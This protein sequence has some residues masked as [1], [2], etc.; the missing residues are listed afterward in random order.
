M[1]ISPCLIVLS[2]I[3]ISL[4]TPR[5]SLALQTALV[6]RYDVM[7]SR[8]INDPFDGLIVY[9]IDSG[10]GTRG[11]LGIDTVI[12]S[13]SKKEIRVSCSGYGRFTTTQ[14]VLK[15]GIANGRQYSYYVDEK[16]TNS[17]I[18]PNVLMFS[19]RGKIYTY[20]DGEVSKELSEA[21][22]NA[23][24]GD[25]FIRA[26]WSNTYITLRVGPQTV[27]AWKEIFKV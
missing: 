13:W 22:A 25:M 6:G 7:W 3:F 26:A 12:S 17:A 11:T 27:A 20:S 10:N 16:V 9:D 2:S 8:V 19:I 14:R 15:Q 1:K 21:L 24:P 18:A 5:T 4:S 23:P